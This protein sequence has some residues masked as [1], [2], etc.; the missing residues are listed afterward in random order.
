MDGFVNN[1]YQTLHSLKNRDKLTRLIYP[2]SGEMR[3]KMENNE[4]KINSGKIALAVAAVIVLAAA[5]IAIVIAGFGGVKSEEP[6]VTAETVEVVEA[7]IPADGNPDDE[8]AKGSYTASDEEVLA[9]GD[10]VVASIDGHTLTNGQLQIYYWMEVQNFLNSYG[11][12]ASYIGLDVSRGLDTQLCGMAEIPET[13]QQFFLASALNT[14]RNHQ[15]LAAEAE[16]AGFQMDPAMEAELA[17]IPAVL[18]QN[19]LSYGFSSAEELLAFNVGGGTS[20]E[21]YLHFM[22]LYYL[23][24]LYYNEQVEANAPS[25]EEIEAYFTENEEAYMQSGLSREDKYVDVRHVLI[26]PEGADS[27]NIRTETFD[28]AAWET[29]RVKAEELLAA[30][31]EGD[32]S[33]ESFAQ[34]AVEHSQDGSAAGGGLYTNVVK[35]QMVEAFETWCFDAERKYGDYGIVKTEFGYHLMFFVGSRPLWVEYA[36]SDLMNQRAQELLNVLLEK[37]TMEAEFD[38]MLLAYVDI[39]GE[40]SQETPAEIPVQAEPLLN[41][42]NKPVLLIAGVSIAALVTA[43]YV[44]GKKEH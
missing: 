31:E 32:K 11:S 33:E 8:T 10:T 26:M 22:D 4:N 29:S 34:L 14:W 5:L 9:A 38:K 3:I 13:W 44:F 16:K 15:V 42:S 18:E 23:G 6:S 17:G 19:A 24:T 30:W 28:E 27:S 37:Y 20:L 1:L 43:A 25:Q 41:E 7:T 12:Y 36:Q 21:D 39:D 35:G 2:E 40:T